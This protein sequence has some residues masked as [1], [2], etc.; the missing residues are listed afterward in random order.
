MSTSTAMAKLLAPVSCP[1]VSLGP[2]HGRDARATTTLRVSMF[3]VL[4]PSHRRV[5]VLVRV[6]GQP[7]EQRGELPWVNVFVQHVVAQG[8]RRGAA[9]A[10]ALVFDQRELPV[11][12]CL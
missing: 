9:R 5:F 6:V 2:A 8:H 4:V 11:R 3:R 7:V 10:K 1:M 12:R